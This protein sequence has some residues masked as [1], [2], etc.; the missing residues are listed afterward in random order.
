VEHEK[1]LL[2]LGTEPLEVLTDVEL[3]FDKQKVEL[4]ACVFEVHELPKSWLLAV[5]DGE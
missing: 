3:N 4:E 5:D 2:L 1:R